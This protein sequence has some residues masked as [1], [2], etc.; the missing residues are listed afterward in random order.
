[1]NVISNGGNLSFPAA[2]LCTFNDPTDISVLPKL[3][4]LQGNG[5]FSS[6][7]ALLPGSPGVDQGV[8]TGCP[9][10]DQRGYPRPV[11]SKCDIGAFEAP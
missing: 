11:N 9:L 8:L 5:G 1:V 4:P 3:G 7:L 10:T 6:T 2:P